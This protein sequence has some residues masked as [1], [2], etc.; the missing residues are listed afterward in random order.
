MSQCAQ[1]VAACW[2]A[3][4]NGA[5]GCPFIICLNAAHITIPALL[6]LAVVWIQLYVGDQKAGPATRILCKP[7]LDMEGLTDLVKEKRA[8]ALQHCDGAELVIYPHG[9]LHTLASTT[10][11]CGQRMQAV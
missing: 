8:V 2:V 11:L 7:D 3:S 6:L 10:Q 4:L 1:W 9:T 5:V